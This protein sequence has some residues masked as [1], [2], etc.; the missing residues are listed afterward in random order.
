MVLPNYW[1]P[2]LS[3]I[4]F[5]R[6]ALALVLECYEKRATESMPTHQGSFFRLQ[7][8][9]GLT[10]VGLFMEGTTLTCLETY[11]DAKKRT[12]Q[13]TQGS[14]ADVA[15]SELPARD[16]QRKAQTLYFRPV[17]NLAPNLHSRS[18]PLRT[19]H[20]RT[21]NAL[22]PVLT[23]TI[24]ATHQPRAPTPNSTI[25]SSQIRCQRAAQHYP[26]DRFAFPGPFVKFF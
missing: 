14:Q 22:R 10:L 2:L 16:S 7:N 9:K 24:L 25:F 23:S 18:Y 19:K 11:S 13:H 1:N 12:L 26:Q 3:F 4:S 15:S 5:W 17:P 21:W 6:A 20:P 8:T